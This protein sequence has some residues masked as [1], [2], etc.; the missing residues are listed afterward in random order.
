MLYNILFTC[1]PIGWFATYDKELNYD[2]L[3][4]NPK[5]YKKGLKKGYFNKIIFWRWYFYGLVAGILIYLQIIKTFNKHDLE[6]LTLIGHSILLCIV[7]VVNFKLLI[8]TRTHNAF[9]IFLF[10][11]STSSYFITLYLTNNLIGMEIFNVFEMTMKNISLYITVVFVVAACMMAEYAWESGVIL[12][13]SLIELIK[14]TLNDYK[15]KKK[16]LRLKKI[17]EKNFEERRKKEK[18]EIIDNDGDSSKDFKIDFC[19]ESIN[20]NT[21]KIDDNNYNKGDHYIFEE[22]TEND[23]KNDKDY[24][25]NNGFDKAIMGTR[26]RCKKNI[27]IFFI[28]FKFYRYWILSN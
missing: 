23:L 10:I 5:Y 2:E 12:F 11:F 9:S 3:E 27:F 6:E 24:F 13:N 22:N 8:K 1:Y 21:N 16:N 14:K 20:R 7:L 18:E 15:N 25:E 26:K 4:Q 28:L 19:R 17:H